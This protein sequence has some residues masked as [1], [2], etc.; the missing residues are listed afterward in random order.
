MKEKTSSRESLT[1]LSIVLHVVQ[2]T[3]FGLLGF[4]NCGRSG[5]VKN[6]A[7]REHSSLK[8]ATWGLNS[9]K[10]GRKSVERCNKTGYAFA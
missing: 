7:T 1:G 2:R 5:N 6:A 9:E 4:L 3:F 8:E 10:S